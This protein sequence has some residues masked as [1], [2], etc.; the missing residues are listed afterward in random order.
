MRDPENFP[1][2]II[3][4]GKGEQ[5]YRTNKHACYFAGKN[6]RCMSRVSVGNII[7]ALNIYVH[8]YLKLIAKA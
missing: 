8:D 1:E 6:S 4:K 3:R 7:I 2:Q 5:Q